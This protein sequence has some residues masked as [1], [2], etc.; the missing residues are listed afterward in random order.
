MY[1]AAKIAIADVKLYSHQS[2]NCFSQVFLCL[3]TY[4][5]PRTDGIIS[6]HR[7][8]PFFSLALTLSQDGSQ[9]RAAW[10][11]FSWF[12]LPWR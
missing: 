2:V 10:V 3:G 7:F 4:Y 12:I 1:R 9:N 8:K 5:G 11:A 6:Y